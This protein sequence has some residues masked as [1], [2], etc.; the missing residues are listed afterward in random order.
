MY[1]D[2][3]GAPTSSPVTITYTSK[4]SEGGETGFNMFEIVDEGPIEG[5]VVSPNTIMGAL[6]QLESKE[7]NSLIKRIKLLKN[8][9]GR[10]VK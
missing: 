1:P 2:Y 4:G 10:E 9:I 3:T 6:S 5:G 7:D 8:T